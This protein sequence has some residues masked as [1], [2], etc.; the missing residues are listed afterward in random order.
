MATRAPCDLR[1]VR[2]MRKELKIITGTR[3]NVK[4][5]S[6]LLTGPLG[7]TLSHRLGRRVGYSNIG[8]QTCDNR[9]EWRQ[10]DIHIRHDYHNLVL[11]ECLSSKAPTSSRNACLVQFTGGRYDSP[12]D[13]QSWASIY[14]Q[15]ALHRA[16]NI[17]RQLGVATER[18]ISVSIIG[19]NV[20]IVI[21]GVDKLNCA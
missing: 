6:M 9:V 1:N 21:Y 20:V 4:T 10:A 16:C 7:R 17:S 2:G 8:Q 19:K 3:F 12:R 15:Q 14:L 13:L 5:E 11:V 18:K